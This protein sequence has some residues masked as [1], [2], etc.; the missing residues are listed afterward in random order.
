MTKT[1]N[2]LV[3]DFPNKRSVSESIVFGNLC[4][5]NSL[6]TNTRFRNEYQ[7]KKLMLIVRTSELIQYIFT[8]LLGK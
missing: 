8:R 3:F 6:I 2:V 4:Q 5:S 7:P 1:N